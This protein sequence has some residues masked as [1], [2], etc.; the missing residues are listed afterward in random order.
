MDT[1]TPG[2]QSPG[3]GRR[4]E[5]APGGKSRGFFDDEPVLSTVKVPSDP[6]EVVVNHASFRVRL[7]SPPSRLP[8]A[9][10]PV[11]AETLS[12]VRGAVPVRRAARRRT[13][14]VWSG[15]TEPGDVRATRLLQAVRR[16]NIE[17]EALNATTQVL[18]RVVPGA[19][20]PPD[21]GPRTAAVATDD[22]P[23][24]IIAPRAPQP[25]EHLPLGRP[26]L[27]GVRPAEGAYDLP[28][29][30]PHDGRDDL[31]YGPHHPYDLYEAD[32]GEDGDAGGSPR[33]ELPRHGYYPGRRMNLGVVLLPLRIFLGFISVYA[34]MGKL[35][36]PVYF[37]GGERGS[38]VSW[39]NS[40]EPW[41]VAEPLHAFALA[42]PV[43]AGLFVAFLQIVVGVLTVLGLW[44]RAA[45]GAGALLSVTLI[46]TVSW[47]TVPVY[48]APDI[49]YLAAWSP[50]VIAGAPYYSLDARLAGEAWRTLGPRVEVW[51]LRR[52]VLRR[53][54]VVATVVLGLTLLIGSVMGSAVRSARVATVPE[55]GG[56][57]TNNQPGSPLP[58]KS[59]E[60]PSPS[61][62]GTG[63]GRPDASASA[64]PSPSASSPGATVPSAGDT[65]GGA[66]PDSPS[67]QQTVQA[68]QRPAPPVPVPDTPADPGGTGG[69]GDTGTSG[70][71]GGGDD[72]DDGADSGDGGGGGALGGLLG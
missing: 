62:S 41:A 22:G 29:D 70:G 50:L 34:G 68:P 58:R 15:R 71:T 64:E 60:R 33:R 61:T 56:P 39:L 19:A 18:P 9:R 12:A 7:A 28:D 53:G 45:A 43:G 69:S 46:V 36:D 1:R 26:L 31:S 11:G 38:L 40:L 10:V 37:D 4:P 52:R 32:D 25:P 20:P 57:L 27:D 65:G 24:T 47:R 2:T 51:E 14:V 44:Q 72:G 63:S 6:A 8:R 67:Q 16:A 54:A 49:I 59:G 17:G 55:P 35:C 21:D 23:P 42:H 48:D 5:E 66:Q 3:S 13:P 30:E